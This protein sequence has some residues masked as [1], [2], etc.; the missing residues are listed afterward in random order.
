MKKFISL[1]MSAVMLVSSVAVGITVQA[2]TVEDNLRAQGFPESYIEDLATLQKA[3]PNWKFVAFKTGLDFD[4]AVKGELSGTP[5]TEEN[6][7]AYL[8]PRNWLNE[9][10]VFQFESI[11][12][13]DAVQ[14]VS[15]VN[16]ILKNTWMA[17]SKINY[18]DTQGVSKT[19]TEVNTYA[20]AMIKA[21]NDTNLSANY[22]AAKI[23]QENGRTENTAT[24]VCGK[25]EPFKGIYNYFNIGAYT[26][27]M[28]GLAWAAGFLKANKD[29]VLF[30]GA[31]ATAKPI[32]TVSN[33]QRMAY[34]KEEGDYYR[35]TLYDELDNGK[36]DD[37]E[38]GYILKSDVNTTYMGNYGRPWTDP[39]KAIYNGAKYIANGYLT[40]QFTMYLQ[41]YNV[42]SQSG[43]LYR[44]EYM[45]NVSGAASE[46]YHLY[47]GYAKAGL[48]NSAHTFY[49]PVFNNMPNDN[50]NIT[51]T[52]PTTTT[53]NYTPAKVKLTSLT[54]LKGHKIKAKWNKCST[55]ATGYQIYWA[56]D[57]KFKKVVAKTTTRG[58]SKVTYTGKNFTKG[59]KYYVRIRAYKKAGGKTYYG[60]WSNIKAKTSK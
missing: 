38:I 39:N 56:K 43:S 51:T 23:R 35:V 60:P 47:S 14:S 55:S 17:N 1:V 44:H 4:D 36:Y 20:D 2:G 31:N 15:S 26:T 58:R 32:V 11:R 41:K 40:Y 49:I 22:I 21:S 16:A 24:A 7:R 3:H 10:Y 13:S 9:K 6:L 54:A 33:G 59:R 18:F 12:K 25:K 57:K 46:G 42:N 34:I 45:T 27:A 50:S 28:D 5:T 30:D 29:T 19:V 37:K 52:A 48:L 53:K 8:D